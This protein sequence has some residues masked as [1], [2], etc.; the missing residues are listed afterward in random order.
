MHTKRAGLALLIGA[1][2][3][4]LTLGACS[5]EDGG[6]AGPSGLGGGGGN[7]GASGS[8]GSGAG[9]V[10]DGGGDA[11]LGLS[12]TP[13]N[14]TLIYDTSKPA[15]T[16]QFQ[17]VSAAGTANALWAVDRAEIGSISATGLF[18]AAGTAA[19]AATVE[20]TVGTVKLTT[21]VNVE[22]LAVQNGGTPTT[23]NI[24]AGGGPG[25]VGGEG[26]GAAVDATLVGIL[27]GTAQTDPQMAL[28]YPYA[29]TV[30]PLGVLPPLMMWK[31]SAT[32][33]VADAVKIEL[34]APGYGY[35]GYFGRPPPLAA[36]APFVRHPID[37][38]TW[39]QAT[40]SAA[41]GALTAKI[42][43]AAG[44]VAYG[45]ITV[46][47]KVAAGR[48]K[49]TVYYQSYGTNLAKNYPGAK[50]GDGTF[51]GAT[52]AIKP[53]ATDPILVAGKSGSTGDCRVCHSV[54]ADGTR[55]IVQH[56][57]N[58]KRSSSYDL[59]APFPETPY[60]ASTDGNIGWIGMTKDGKLGLSNAVPIPGGAN[61][62]Q[63]GLFD[64]ATGAAVT[65]TGLNSFVTRAGFPA[66]APD[67][68][69]VA[70]NLHAGP[71]SASTGAGDG[72][73]LAIM[74]F[75][76]NTNAF[77]NGRLLYKSSQ[78]PGWPSFLPTAAGV[79]FQTEVATNSSGEYFATRYGAKG[80][81]WWV[82]VATQTP[83]RLDNLNG[84]GYLP[85]GPNNH[86]D[87][88][89]LNYEP[90]VGP[91]ASGGY[92]WVVFMSRRLYGNVATIDPWASDPREHDLVANTTTKKLWV[93][94]ID[95]NAKPGTDPS[96]P[97]FYVPAQELL[98]GN[99]RGYWVLD[100]CK[101]DGSTCSS[102]DECCGGF[103]QADPNSG[104]LTCGK[105]TNECS[106]EFDKCSID[107]DCCDPKLSCIN[108]RCA[109]S[110]PR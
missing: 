23:G 38:A 93:A 45:P 90:T 6:V 109:L 42:T 16:V 21:Q 76:A 43:V 80:E 39:E 33:A 84:K 51:G 34:S 14:P 79:V 25:G 57:N 85:T 31:A 8:G 63:S 32:A 54:N 22:I 64:M 44:G 12:I 61:G 65:A 77:S 86:A 50:G 110:I 58:Y 53:G 107:A 15:P 105:K 7:S 91:V 10:I 75:D 102:G 82:D 28:L 13:P 108:E 1:L 48:L 67:T 37:K 73:Q 71:G 4:G 36:G 81:L 47:W 72:T 106:L 18:T 100:P 96:H 41:G 49:G 92:A 74:D 103:C 69:S 56:G 104:A 94:A 9:V 99:A 52:L 68:K 26:E 89:V 20:A 35:T 101:A 88:S 60:A 5:G 70:F 19:G 62:S 24:K 29:N 83:T 98:A 11:A 17:V 46:P 87:D 27:D 97:A 2:G 40:L 66:F 59:S 95:L 30:W 3:I 78:R 55:M